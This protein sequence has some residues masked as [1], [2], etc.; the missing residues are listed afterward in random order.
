MEPMALLSCIV[1]LDICTNCDHF[2]FSAVSPKAGMLVY[3]IPLVILIIIVIVIDWPK[4]DYDSEKERQK[5][6]TSD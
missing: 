1:D 5:N 3:P 2:A 6:L 4:T